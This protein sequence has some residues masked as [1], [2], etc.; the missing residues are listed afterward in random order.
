MPDE[1]IVPLWAKIIAGGTAG[2]FGTSLILCVAR[3]A[4]RARRAAAAALPPRAQ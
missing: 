3:V 2:V 4:A 1:V